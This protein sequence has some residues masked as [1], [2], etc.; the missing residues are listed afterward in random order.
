MAAEGLES[1]S[2]NG[3]RIEILYSIIAFVII[4]LI[5]LW[6]ALCVLS[7]GGWFVHRHESLERPEPEEL[8]PEFDAP[9]IT[10]R[11]PIWWVFAFFCWPVLVALSLD[12]WYV[13]RHGKLNS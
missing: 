12:A 9:G 6:G 5:C 13:K 1:T 3:D 8:P 4:G 11:D 10:W 7:I 2:S